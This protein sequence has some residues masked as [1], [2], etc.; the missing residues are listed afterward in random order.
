[1]KLQIEDVGIIGKAEVEISGLT[2]IAGK[3]DTGKTTIGKCLYDR[4][5]SSISS[6]EIQILELFQKITNLKKENKEKYLDKFLQLEEIYGNFEDAVES[7]SGF[8]SDRLKRMVSKKLKRKKDNIVDG[9][10][11]GGKEEIVQIVFIDSPVIL[12]MFSYLKMAAIL[13][14][15]R[16]VQGNLDKYHSDLI[17]LLSQNAEQKEIELCNEINSIICGDIL[18]NQEKDDIFYKKKNVGTFEMKDTANGIKMFGYLQILLRNGTIWKDSVL[19]LDEPE[20]HLHPEWQLKYAEI[21]VKLVQHG[22]KVLVTS[23]SPYMIEALKRYADRDEIKPHFYLAEDR[24]MK[25]VSDNLEPIFK[26]L[27]EPMQAL[28]ELKWQQLHG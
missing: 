3:N 1:M 4:V 16:K 23:H 19:I 12:D 11:F 13:L 5:L 15:E 9:L 26:T 17:I 7:F 10:V 24:T 22:V 27:A 8:D 28:K 2:I 14:L 20:V 21:I 25:D 6:T 18:Y